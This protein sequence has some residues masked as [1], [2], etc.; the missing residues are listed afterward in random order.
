MRTHEEVR[1]GTCFIPWQKRSQKVTIKPCNT[2]M[3]HVI[4]YSDP[5]VKITQPTSYFPVSYV[6]HAGPCYTV[7]Q[8]IKNKRHLNAAK[9]SDLGLFVN[10]TLV[11]RKV[12]S[13]KRTSSKAEVQND[14]WDAIFGYTI[15]YLKENCLKIILNILPTF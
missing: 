5:I 3:G 7:S 11:S 2:I 12:V 15:F 13:T 1:A 4:V 14:L 6:P 10:M 9:S 8:E